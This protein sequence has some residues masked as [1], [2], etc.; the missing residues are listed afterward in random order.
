MAKWCDVVTTDVALGN[1]LA[2]KIGTSPDD[3]KA[4]NYGRKLRAI[5]GE[6]VEVAR[7]TGGP[8][9]DA[10]AAAVSEF[11]TSGPYPLLNAAGITNGEIAAAKLVLTVSVC[12]YGAQD[13]LAFWASLGYEPVVISLG[14]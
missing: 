14:V 11:N 3:N 4:F 5:G 13:P 9:S 2:G 10:I 6:N 1:A 8:M 12:E 7:A